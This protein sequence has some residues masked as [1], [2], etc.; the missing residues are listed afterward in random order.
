ME[1]DAPRVIVAGSRELGMQYDLVDEAIAESPFEPEQIVHGG[2]RGID[3][4]AAK[5]AHI[6]NV[7]CHEYEADWDEHGKAAGPIRNQE[8]A[9]YADALIAIWDG[10]S[11]GTRDMVEKALNEGL[12]LYVKT[13]GD[14]NGR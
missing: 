11:S 1:N 14:S 3:T 7:V 13:V 2:A 10:E 12:Y 5:W 8:M 6:N 9:E 4:A